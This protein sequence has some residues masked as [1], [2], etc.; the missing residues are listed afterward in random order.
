MKDLDKLFNSLAKSYGDRGVYRASEL[1]DYDVVPTGSLS[2]DFALGIGGLPLGRLVELG[3][4]NGAGKTLFSMHIMNN[5]LNQYPDGFV[6]FLDLEHR[7]ERDWMANFV[8]DMD[9]VI[10]LRPDSVEE[11]GDML[12]D[13][14]QSGDMRLAVWDS[15]GG[16]PAAAEL[17]K[18]AF[19]QQF[20]GNSKAVTALSKHATVLAA[21]YDFTFLGINQIREDMSGYRQ[22][23]TPSGVAWKHA[24]SIRLQLKRVPKSADGELYEK[25]N[26]E[27]LQVGFKTSVKVIKSS[28]GAP[29]RVAEFWFYNVEN[30]RGF[31]MD[32]TEEVIRLSA[33]TGVVERRGA[34]YYHEIF[35]GGQLQGATKVG[36]FLRDNTE[37]TDLLFKLTME[38]M[39]SGKVDLSE[40]VPL[41]DP[42]I[43]LEEDPTLTL[44]EIRA[45]A[46][47]LKDAES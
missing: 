2:V 26:G 36:A 10:V 42:N 33:L 11:G 4:A 5:Y 25:I 27:D 47:S 37:A 43:S 12:K 22:Y 31:G 19:K 29:G 15:I 34:W 20:G 8:E 41:E 3:G 7:I 14:A 45:R 39:K 21:K 6:S 30:S 17:E 44:E 13:V 24:C 40:I 28:V 38:T 23:V 35:P 18:S 32:K 1:P 9:R 16:A 46:R